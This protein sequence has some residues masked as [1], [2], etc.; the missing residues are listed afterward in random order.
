MAFADMGDSDGDS[1][2]GSNEELS[3]SAAAPVGSSR[4][5]AQAQA[6]AALHRPPP[7][8][9]ARVAAPQSPPPPPAPPVRQPLAPRVDLLNSSPAPRLAH[10]G[11]KAGLLFGKQGV[12]SPTGVL[13]PSHGTVAPG[14][15]TYFD[16]H[17]GELVTARLLRADSGPGVL[18][19]PPPMLVRVPPA[20]EAEEEDAMTPSGAAQ[21]TSDDADALLPPPPPQMAAVKV[22]SQRARRVPAPPAPPSRRGG[23]PAGMLL[24]SV[25]VTAAGVGLTL[26]GVKHRDTGVRAAAAAASHAQRALQ[27][28]AASGQ[29][30]VATALACVPSGEGHPPRMTE[31]QR[32]TAAP[33]KARDGRSPREVRWQ[34]HVA[35]GRG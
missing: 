12:E 21:A 33:A 1:S 16:T 10:Q 31:W 14:M 22:A 20:E 4:I 19:E 28:A 13:P 3:G 25:V 5:S 29:A 8:V 30:V 27:A 34:P 23:F 24:R 2:D 15:Y 18:V 9:A 7:P 26:L 32:T 6:P 11:S 35:L 17:R